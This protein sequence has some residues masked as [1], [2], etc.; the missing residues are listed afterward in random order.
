VV[1]LQAGEG[2][3]MLRIE[4]YSKRYDDLALQTRDYRV[5]PGARGSSRGIDVFYKGRLPVAGIELRTISSYLVAKRS[6][7]ESGRIVRAPF[8]VTSTH[9]IIAERGFANGVRLGVSYRS[10]TGKP[11]TPIVGATYDAAR[12]LYVPIYGAS[13][14]ERFP[15]LRRMDISISRFRLLTP[16]LASVMYASVSNVF[17]RAN[18][19]SWK[20]SRDYTKREGNKSIFN[21]AVYFGASLMWQ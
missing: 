8:D 19:Q 14:S 15:S 6:D 11:Y 18:V 4:A 1:G 21:R 20:Y 13:M 17:D 16:S 7:P 9:A 5:R 12:G 10:A 3:L 2:A